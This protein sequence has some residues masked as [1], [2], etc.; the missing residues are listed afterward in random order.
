MQIGQEM[1][2]IYTLEVLRSN[3][4]CSFHPIQMIQQ[5]LSKG[6]KNAKMLNISTFLSKIGMVWGQ[7]KSRESQT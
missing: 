7:Y 4:Q 2:E 3:L 1:S 5:C 6:S